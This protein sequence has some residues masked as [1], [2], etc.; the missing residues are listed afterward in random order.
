MLVA[1]LKNTLL[2]GAELS[3]FPLKRR[4]SSFLSSFLPF[5]LFFSF[6]FPAVSSL[7]KLFPY[8][9]TGM[10]S[11]NGELICKP[12]CAAPEFA[13]KLKENSSR[14]QIFF[15]GKKTWTKGSG[16]LRGL[17]VGEMCLSHRHRE[18]ISGME[19][20]ASTSGSV[21]VA[22]CEFKGVGSLLVS[23]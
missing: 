23:P 21:L 15:P 20:L 19:L 4:H 16:G 13:H 8:L 17:A 14:L 18:F 6:F 9:V 3:F 7:Q 22:S 11:E 2:S 1:D 12:D 5:S 10:L